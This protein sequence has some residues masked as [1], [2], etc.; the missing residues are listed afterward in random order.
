M[1]L[2]SHVQ[3]LGG[4]T[5]TATLLSAGQTRY[6]LHRA[7]TRG[8]LVQPRRGW[9][10][11]A[12]ADP[13]LVVA[14]THNVVLSCITQ[15]KRL[16]LWVLRDDV[17][18]VATRTPHSRS[19]AMRCVTHWNQPVTMRAP[20]M[21]EDQIENELANVATCQPRD[22]AL[23]IIDSALNKGMVTLPSLEM[24]TIPRSLRNLLPFALPFSDSGLE[25]LFRTRL[26][27]LGVPIAYQIWLIGHRVD[28]VI[29]D[30]LVVQ[31]DGLQF[32]Q[33]SRREED[34]QH[35]ALL[36]Q[37]GYHV[38]RLSYSQVVYRWPE[39]Q[40]LVTN[41]IAQGRHLRSTPLSVRR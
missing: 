20:T 31:I 39:T 7:L 24:L 8:A 26:A 12:D 32:H 6:R 41:A 38:I 25:T 27:W 3:S 21:L 33:G 29:G 35:D 9:V 30:R 34:I 28:F 5:A 16:G 22:A 17:A 1:E 13:M 10:A 14:A 4:V 18:H 19:P 40:A 23:T 36:A 15:A 11:L 37:E 2:L